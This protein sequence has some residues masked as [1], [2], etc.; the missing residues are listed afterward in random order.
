[1]H[2]G[3][4]LFAATAIAGVAFAQAPPGNPPPPQGAPGN[5]QPGQPMAPGP[6]GPPQPPQGGPPGQPGQPGMG[7]QPG[8][9]GMGSP[10]QPGMMPGGPGPG[11]QG[12]PK[13]P[14]MDEKACKKHDTKLRR[15]AENCLKQKK[16]ENR[17]K[18]FDKMQGQF[19][20]GFFEQCRAVIE[21]I[22]G[23]IMAKEKSKYP[24]QPSAV[25][26]GNK[27]GPGGPGGHG[28]AHGPDGSH[29]GPQMGDPA[30]GPMGKPANCEKLVNKTR[31]AGERCLKMKAQDKRKVCF[32]RV[33]QEVDK[34]P[35]LEACDPQMSPVK[36]EFQ[37]KE[38]EK[39]PDQP[40]S[41]E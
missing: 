18:C 12:G 37:M 11:M 21:P 13:G 17:N 23:E 25:E 32:D 30:K 20:P 28:G 27:G 10:N 14:M 41:L 4:S 38:K 40:S 5:P 33:K 16:F 35:G 7:G 15:Q 29:G 39:Y 22:K 2:F 19:P 8:Q 36:T 9:P 31:K 3:L 24:D 34:T 1:M 26:G 6:N